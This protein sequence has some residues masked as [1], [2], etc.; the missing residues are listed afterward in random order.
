[1]MLEADQDVVDLKNDNI[2]IPQIR[3]DTEVILALTLERIID[4]VRLFDQTI[5]RQ[6][7]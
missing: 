6:H 3:K 1:M 5:R 4:N 7:D 2:E